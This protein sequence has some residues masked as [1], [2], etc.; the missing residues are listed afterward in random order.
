MFN[1]VKIPILG[2]VENMSYFIPPDMPD[3]R[4]SIFGEGGGQKLADSFKAPLLGKIPMT[5]DIMQS[6]ET[7]DPIVH[8]QKSGAVASAYSEIFAKLETEIANWE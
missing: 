8:A 6:G 1:Q 4:Y 7:G 5:M 3:K 2:V